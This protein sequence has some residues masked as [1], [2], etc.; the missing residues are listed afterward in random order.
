MRRLAVLILSL[1]VIEAPIPCPHSHK[2]LDA[3]VLQQHLDACHDG[4]DDHHDDW[5]WHIIWIGQTPAPIEV[6]ILALPQSELCHWTSYVAQTP[7]WRFSVDAA[8]H[9]NSPSAIPPPSLDLPSLNQ[10]EM[11]KQLCTLLI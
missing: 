10:R 4:C 11:Y 5:H 2:S 8:S 6:R 3:A 1:T 7:D 9:S